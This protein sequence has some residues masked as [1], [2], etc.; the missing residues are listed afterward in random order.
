M[1]K[2]NG[3][4]LFWSGPYSQWVESKFIDPDTSIEFL[5]A[6]HYMMWKKAEL[7]GD[8]EICKK[9]LQ[10]DSPRDA[11]ALGRT[12]KN[13]NVDVWNNVCVDI[14]ARGNY[15]KFTQ[16][17][18]LLDIM[19]ADEKYELVEAS[20]YDRIWGIGLG[21]NDPLSWN[22]NTWRGTNLLGIA[23]MKARSKIMEKNVERETKSLFV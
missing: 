5:T 20:P 3:L 6:E 18:W 13:F 4:L 10:T 17:K 19:L 12:V 15:L 14:V 2:E 9:V 7:F 21:M 16:N 22:K 23:L 11:K 8:K 1:R